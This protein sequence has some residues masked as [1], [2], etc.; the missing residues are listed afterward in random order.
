MIL[1]TFAGM[2]LIFRGAAKSVYVSIHVDEDEDR[3]VFNQDKEVV[4]NE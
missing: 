4:V 1:A 2:M 3:S